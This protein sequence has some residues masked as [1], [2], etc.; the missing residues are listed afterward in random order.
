LLLRFDLGLS[1]R[2][3]AEIQESPE[4]TIKSRVYTLIRR[5]KET[6][7]DPGATKPVASETGTG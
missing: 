2:E 1:Y 5:L 6:L 7:D 3:I 4:T